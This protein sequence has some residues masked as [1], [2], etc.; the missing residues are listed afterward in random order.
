MDIVEYTLFLV[1]SIAKE[2]DLVSVKEI[3]SDE[4][5]INLEILVKEADMGSVI[6]KSG[7]VLKALRTM[8]QASFCI[9]GDNMNEV[10]ELKDTIK[11]I[12]KENLE[13]ILD[14]WFDTHSIFWSSLIK[15]GKDNAITKRSLEIFK[16]F[17]EVV[18]CE[19]KVM[20]AFFKLMHIL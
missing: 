1:K 11:L 14:F 16:E 13:E 18:K 12:R 6:G 8:V 10:K 20:K 5:T 3:G 7:S 9:W 19:E 4:E 2:D 17:L 15:Y